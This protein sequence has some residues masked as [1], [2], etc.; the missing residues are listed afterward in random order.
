MIFAESYVFYE[1]PIRMNLY[2]WPTP[3][4][5]PKHKIVRVRS[6]EL[7]RISHLVK[8]VRIG[9]IALAV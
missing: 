7:A 1:L 3:N 9:E 2:E 6:Y 5:A 4:S 8:Y